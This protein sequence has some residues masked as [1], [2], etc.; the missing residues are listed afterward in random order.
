MQNI[1]FLE[2]KREAPVRSSFYKGVPLGLTPS[3][4]LASPGLFS[5]LLPRGSPLLTF[6]RKCPSTIQ[7]APTHRKRIRDSSFNLPVIPPTGE[8]LC[9]RRPWPVGGLAAKVINVPDWQRV[10]EGRA[11]VPPHRE[12]R[13]G[14]TPEAEASAPRELQARHLFS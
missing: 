1:P 10:Q 13:K 4:R 11:L 12:S 3:A 5:H 2:S 14:M 7:K 6:L 8:S 9:A